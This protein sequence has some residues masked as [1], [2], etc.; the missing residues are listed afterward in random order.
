MIPFKDE[1]LIIFTSQYSWKTISS[2]KDMK[3]AT[4][5]IKLEFC[6]IFQSCL[7]RCNSIYHKAEADH[8]WKSSNSLLC[9]LIFQRSIRFLKMKHLTTERTGSFARLSF[10]IYAYAVRYLLLNPGP[11]REVVIRGGAWGKALLDA[12]GEEGQ[13]LHV[14]SWTKGV[15]QGDSLPPSLSVGPYSNTALKI[16]SWPG[17]ADSQWG[18]LCPL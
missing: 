18:S 4:G 1:K 2:F 17:I 16:L 9:K 12:L 14:S 11:P 6:W 7:L 15:R 5:H 3:K 13:E 10:G 8:M